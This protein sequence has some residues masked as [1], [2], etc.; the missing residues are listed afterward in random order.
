VN[1]DLG[2]PLDDSEQEA[3]I[4]AW[5]SLLSGDYSLGE[6]PPEVQFLTSGQDSKLTD[7]HWSVWGWGLV[8]TAA[9][10][11]LLCGWLVDAGVE[12]GPAM[13]DRA[14]KGMDASDLAVFDGVIYDRFWPR[15]AGDGHLAVDQ[16]LHDSGWQPAAVYDYAR[17][18]GPQKGRAYPSKGAGEDSRSKAPLVRW[19]PSPT[20]RVT[21]ARGQVQV[22]TDATLQR[23]DMNTYA[24]KS[25]LLGWP[26]SRF[27]PAAGE[28]RARLVLPAD[29]PPEMLQHLASERLVVDKDTKKKVWKK[30][31]ANH[32]LDTAIMAYA[33]AK[34][35]EPHLEGKTRDE[36][37]AGVQRA[38][39]DKNRR[40]AAPARRAIRTR[41]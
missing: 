25:D 4:A 41:Y 32:W 39:Q 13:H 36:A 11:T 20:W 23:A 28:P 22:V 15:R 12:P 21:D 2:E 6:V 38:D 26:T 10:V 35:L 29:T 33:A 1:K 18:P 17:A 27:A 31:G 37:V 19:V 14:R 5:E 7:L 9:G 30:F 8:R 3:P 24:L 16:G 40:A 34:Q